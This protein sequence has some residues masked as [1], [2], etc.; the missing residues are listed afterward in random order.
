MVVVIAGKD[1]GAVGPI[2]KVDR[3][4]KRVMLEGVN[5]VLRNIKAE[6]D[7]ATGDVIREGEQVC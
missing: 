3:K 1:K 2:I 4:Y 7:E 6:T 5:K